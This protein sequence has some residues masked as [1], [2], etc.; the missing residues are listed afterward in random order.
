MPSKELG[1]ANDPNYLGGKYP[2]E[3]PDKSLEEWTP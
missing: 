2:P 1:S 3:H